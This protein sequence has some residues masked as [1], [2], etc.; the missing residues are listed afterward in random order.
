MDTMIVEKVPTSLRGELSRW[1]TPVSCGIYVGS[2][3]AIVR[4]ELWKQALSKVEEG[5]VIQLWSCQKEP[6]Y[7]LRVSGLKD[8]VLVDLEGLPM[9]A[10]RDAAWQKVVNKFEPR[11]L[12]QMEDVASIDLKPP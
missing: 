4:N 2:I 3:S 1:L 8:S 6:G 12:Q 9:I 10:I 7:Q 11:S 5:M